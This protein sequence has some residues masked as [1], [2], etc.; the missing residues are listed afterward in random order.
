MFKED[1]NELIL[2]GRIVN[3]FPARKC[4]IVTL[5]TG[6]RT[7]PKVVC[8][9]ENAQTI[10]EEYKINDDI[11]LLCNIQ[12]SKRED[13]ITTS[14]FCTKILDGSCTQEYIICNSFTVRGHILS[15]T[16]YKDLTKIIVKTFTNGRYSTVPICIYNKNFRWHYERHQ[17]ICVQG[18]VE[19]RRKSSNGKT[20]Y[21]TNFV[22]NQVSDY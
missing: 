8:W 6:N 13:R 18:V 22:G 21:Y 1:K 9:Q 7:F 17:P 5:D 15:A 12:S 2:S 10:L 3:I 11:Y 19:T 20:N 16:L 14:I 4:T